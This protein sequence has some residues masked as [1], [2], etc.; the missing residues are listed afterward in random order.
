LVQGLIHIH[1]S[2]GY[3]LLF[4]AL[5]NVAGALSVRQSP[6]QVARVVVRS[7]RWGVLGGGRL[8][9]VVGAILFY[10]QS[11]PWSSWWAWASIG[12]WGPVEVVAR[13]MIY[14]EVEL[15]ELGSGSLRPVVIGTS[16][17]LVTI[18][19]IFVLMVVQP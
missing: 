18:A 12:L 8:A 1:R 5:A 15:L 19:A 16:L 10:V 3:A 6:A 14:P 2:L 4:L 11:V 17:Q 13:R 9:L 7:V